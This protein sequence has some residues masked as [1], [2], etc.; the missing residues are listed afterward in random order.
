MH[1]DPRRVL[2]YEISLVPRPHP[3]TD[4]LYIAAARGSIYK[5]ARAAHT[6]KQ[7]KPP[8][9]QAKIGARLVSDKRAKVK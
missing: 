1:D 5:L 7:A 8:N 9:K 6:S 3:S 4:R 2:V